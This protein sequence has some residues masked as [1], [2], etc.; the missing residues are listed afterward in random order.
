MNNLCEKCKGA[1][2]KYQLFTTDWLNK[3]G[4]KS[5]HYEGEKSQIVEDDFIQIDKTCPHLKEGLCDIY[6]D[7][8]HVCRDFAVGSEKCLLAM[9]KKNPKLYS[10]LQKDI[11]V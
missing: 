10:T 4:A 2:C 5:V 1:C 7:R 6:E 8:S 9:K 11:N 3:T